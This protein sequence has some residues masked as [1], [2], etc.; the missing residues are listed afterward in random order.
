MAVRMQRFRMTEMLGGPTGRKRPCVCFPAHPAGRDSAGRKRT[1][2]GA[3]TPGAVRRAGA[4]TGSS[5]KEEPLDAEEPDHA[6]SGTRTLEGV[7]QEP[8]ILL[9]LGVGV[10]HDEVP[11]IVGQAHRQAGPQVAATRPVHDATPQPGAEEVDFRFAHGP[12]E[13]EK[14]PIIEV[15]GTVDAVLVEDQGVSQGAL[16]Q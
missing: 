2:H 11:R 9:D 8:V 13:S 4:V 7:E 12:L 6:A 1:P 15:A 10:E 3:A 14:Q 5:G 16:L